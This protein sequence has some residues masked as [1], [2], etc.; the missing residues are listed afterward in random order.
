M[1]W[2]E[3]DFASRSCCDLDL[4]G[5]NPNVENVHILH[6]ATYA[7]TKH[8]KESFLVS[9]TLSFPKMCK[10]VNSEKLKEL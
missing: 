9:K 6:I 4:Q 8:L 3:H 1:L 7:H 5:S 2:V 10:N